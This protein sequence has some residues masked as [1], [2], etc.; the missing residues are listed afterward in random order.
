MITLR[1][2][3]FCKIKLIIFRF[4]TNYKRLNL[5][6]FTHICREIHLNINENKCQTIQKWS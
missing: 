5:C 2:G 1:L 6:L 3:I 4:G